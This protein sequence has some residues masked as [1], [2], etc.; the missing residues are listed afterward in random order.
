M[1]NIRI[2]LTGSLN[3]KIPIRTVPT[4]PMPV[5][6]A[7]AVPIGIVSTAFINNPMPSMRHIANEMYQ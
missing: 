3:T 2:I 6:T 4:A 1:K 5:N 7:Y